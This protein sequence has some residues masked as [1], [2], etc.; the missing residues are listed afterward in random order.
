MMLNR[1]LE[2][3]EFRN[4]IYIFWMETQINKQKLKHLG[5]KETDHAPLFAL[6]DLTKPN[7]KILKDSKGNIF[8]E[9]SII[10]FIKDIIHYDE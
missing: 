4:K 2:R 7:K 10:S 9:N 5:F 8:N 1:I 3:R 6:F